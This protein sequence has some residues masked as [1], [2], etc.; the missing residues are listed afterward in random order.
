MA[1]ERNTED[2]AKAPEPTVDLALQNEQT[3]AQTNAIN[4]AVAASQVIFFLST[5]SGRSR[6]SSSELQIAATFTPG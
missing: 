2:E 5:A 6:V 3:I 1:T 4:D